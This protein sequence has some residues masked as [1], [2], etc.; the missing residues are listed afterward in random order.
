[1]VN[2]LDPDPIDSLI[3]ELLDRMSLEDRVSIANLSEDDIHVLESVMGKYLKHRLDQLSETGEDV[4]EATVILREIWKRL[5][6][7]H[8]LRVVK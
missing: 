6:E 7:T 5:R 1:M 4:E 2:K 8:R 3:T